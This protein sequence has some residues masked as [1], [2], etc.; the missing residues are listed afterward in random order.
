MKRRAT[1]VV[2][3]L[4]RGDGQA[5]RNEQVVWTVAEAEALLR[6]TWAQFKAQCAA[7]DAA[8]VQA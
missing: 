6:S 1:A 8:E 7:A 2:I 5:G 4:V 3:T